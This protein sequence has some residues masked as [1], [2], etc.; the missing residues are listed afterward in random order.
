MNDDVWL[1]GE[2]RI[3]MVNSSIILYDTVFMGYQT[4]LDDL[5]LSDPKNYGNSGQVYKNSKV[6]RTFY[7]DRT[8]TQLF[9]L[10]YLPS[11]CKLANSGHLS[12]L[13]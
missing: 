11:C 8:I 7:S 12:Y 5:M 3:V 10:I 4:K 2:A 6:K 9:K 1:Q 13:P